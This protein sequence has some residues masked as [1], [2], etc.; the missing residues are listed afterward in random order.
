MKIN[1]KLLSLIILFVIVVTVFY[2][3]KQGSNTNSVSTNQ[4]TDIV[5]PSQ[6]SNQN[7][8]IQ[9]L[10]NDPSN[11]QNIPLASCGYI[12]F[13]YSSGG[14]DEYF[15]CSM[16]INSDTTFKYKIDNQNIYFFQNENGTITPQL[17]SN[18]TN[19]SLIKVLWQ[20]NKTSYIILDNDVYFN[21]SKIFGADASTFKLIGLDEFVIGPGGGIMAIDLMIRYSEDSKNVYFNGV[22]IVQADPKSFS[23]LPRR[24]SVDQEYGKDINHVYY[25]GNAIDSADPATFKFLGNEDLYAGDANHIFY[26]GKIVQGADVSTFDASLNGKSTLPEYAA[27]KYHVFLSGQIIS[28]AD[29]KTF[30]YPPDNRDPL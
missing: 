9:F 25:L 27:D 2:Y 17:L 11:S 22:P 28:G 15:P 7:I 26:K 24:L 18:L 21:G 14:V 12:G 4:Y 23:F 29:P 19:N 13:K 20:S 30:V 1:K 8:S 10:A 3:V 16:A 5:S 6:T